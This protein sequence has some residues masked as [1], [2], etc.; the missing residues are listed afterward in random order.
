MKK[1]EPKLNYRLT[2]RADPPE[3][4]GGDCGAMPCSACIWK[5]KYLEARRYLRA[6]NKGAERN[7]MVAELA[8]ARGSKLFR[9]IEECRK[10]WSDERAR[11]I[12]AL[13]DAIR[14]PLGVV[15]TS[16]EEFYEQNKLSQLEGVKKGRT[17]EAAELEG[18]THFV[19]A[20]A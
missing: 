7:A 4:P 11:L 18:L 2:E 12:A 17:L 16:A 19:R 3:T 15:P 10:A 9:E 5:A 14:R 1:F 20:D 6:A 8:T 13:H